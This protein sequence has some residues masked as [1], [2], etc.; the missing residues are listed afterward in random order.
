MLNITIMI[1]LPPQDLLHGLNI[2]H[3]VLVLLLIL[4]DL[5]SVHDHMHAHNL[6]SIHN[7][8]VPLS[9]VVHPKLLHI[10]LLVLDNVEHSSYL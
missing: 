3:A 5:N 9:H 1:D 7:L 2:L 6:L 8:Y 10:P 4:Y